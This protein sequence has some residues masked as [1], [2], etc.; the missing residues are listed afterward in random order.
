MLGFRS[1]VSF[2][3][4]DGFTVDV[5]SEPPCL[6]EEM[7][8]KIEEAELEETPATCP[9]VTE[10]NL[11]EPDNGG[12]N[13]ALDQLSVENI[14]SHVVSHHFSLLYNVVWYFIISK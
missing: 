1:N 6:R 14:T 2:D 12:P 13:N 4:N 9:A 7:T 8:N 5:D 3:D 11:S 10:N